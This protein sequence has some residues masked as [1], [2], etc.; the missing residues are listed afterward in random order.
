L[1]K[2]SIDFL[3]SQLNS[4]N[5]VAYLARAILLHNG[6]RLEPNCNGRSSSLN[7]VETKP[8]VSNP[9]PVNRNDFVKVY[10]NPASSQ[11][12]IEFITPNTSGAFVLYNI[13]GQR[14]IEEKIEGNTNLN[15][16]ISYLPN[17]VYWYEI[18]DAETTGIKGKVLVQ[19]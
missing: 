3:K 17:G 15:I 18:I 4:C 8:K 11:L 19:H 12:I 13:A 14:Q 16:D 10:P 1:P 5:E 7:I 2:N 6:I 9:E